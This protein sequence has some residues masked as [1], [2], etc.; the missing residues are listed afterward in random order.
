MVLSEKAW[1]AI[2]LAGQ[3]FFTMR[4]VVQWIATEKKRKS[5]IPESFWYF[6]IFGSL[7]LLVYSLYRKDPVFIL[8]QAFGTTVYL[9]NLFFI[10][11]EKKDAAS[12]PAAD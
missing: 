11:K 2:G 10:H 12:D 8:G 7:I 6:S 5:V 3:F 1:V 9:R 4:F